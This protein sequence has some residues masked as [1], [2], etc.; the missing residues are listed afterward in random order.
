MLFFLRV[1]WLIRGIICERKVWDNALNVLP[2]H[3]GD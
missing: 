3:F 2:L 1:W